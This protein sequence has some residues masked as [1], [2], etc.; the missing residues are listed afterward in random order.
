MKKAL[1]LSGVAI[2][3]MSGIAMASPTSPCT[4]IGYANGNTYIQ[5]PSFTQNL[6]F[7]NNPISFGTCVPTTVTII[8]SNPPQNPP[9]NA[10]VYISLY[11]TGTPT[12]Y[13]SQ[14]LLVQ[15]TTVISSS[16]LSDWFPAALSSVT[17]VSIVSPA[18][19]WVPASVTVI[20]Q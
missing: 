18:T 2:V 16:S 5:S 1:I 3:L 14:V 6:P 10:P 20:W 15:G 8:V 12:T 4:V 19:P 17:G 7:S 13:T 11:T 9:P